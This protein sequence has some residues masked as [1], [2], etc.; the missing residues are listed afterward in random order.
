MTLIAVS[1]MIAPE[2]VAVAV[3]A[4]ATDLGENYVQ[5]AQAKIEALGRRARWH[6]IGHLQ[7][8]KAAKAAEV[9]DTVQSVDSERLARKL[10]DGA[11]K[12]GRTLDVLVEVNISG[13]PAK[14]G[15]EKNGVLELVEKVTA[16]PNLSLRGLMAIPP[17]LDDPEAIRPY[18]RELAAMFQ[19]LPPENRQVLSMGMS[20]DFETAIEE[21]ATMVRVGTAIFGSRPRR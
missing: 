9:F 8:N 12:A 5:E 14:T 2:L 15:V 6:M 7:T 4:G 20:G 19:K 21:G 16:L 13:E 1:K 18:F 11:V 10:S 17:F 3:D